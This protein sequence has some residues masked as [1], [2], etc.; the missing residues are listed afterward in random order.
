MNDMRALLPHSKKE[1]K[2]DN[3]ARLSP[4]N[5]IADLNN[6]NNVIFF[7]CRKQQDLYLWMAKSPNGPS[8][9]FLVL[10]VHTMEEMKLTGNALKGSRPILSFD[11]AFGEQP[12]WVLIK[13]LFVQ[14][15]GT[16][17]GHRKSKPFID[18]IFHFAIVDQ[19]VWFRNYQVVENEKKERT[20]VE[21]GP[22]FVLHL[23]R[24]F[25]GSFGGPTLY[26]NPNFVTPNKMRQLERK[27]IANNYLERT[28]SKQLHEEKEKTLV[29]PE[30]ELDHVWDT[31]A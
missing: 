15:F 1:S 23:Y 8:V 7:E 21:I 10:N 9:K 14:I 16:P 17:K 30:G 25:S 31:E 26:I 18:H 12:H 6:C 11:K 13:E 29:L 20:L 24:I 27:G 3:K 19:K 4:I 22:R 2:F 5:E 28:R